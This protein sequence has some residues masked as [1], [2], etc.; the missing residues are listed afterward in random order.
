MQKARLTHDL[1]LDKSK[2]T[3]ISFSSIL[4]GAVLEEIAR[5]ISVSEYKENLW[6]KNG[7]V[8]GI[9]RYEKKLAL[10]LEYVYVVFKVGRKDADKTDE[11]FLTELFEG[12]REQAFDKNEDCGILVASSYKI[13]RKHLLIQLCA[14]LGDMK[15]PLSVRIAFLLD[16]EKIP[17]KESLP[18]M[19]FPNVSIEYCGY[20][21]EGV[22]AERYVEVITKLELIQNIGAYYEI[23]RLLEHESVDGRKVKEYIEER[24]GQLRIQKE[25]DRLD[26]IREYKD[27]SYMKKKWKTYLRG[28]NSKEPSW[29]AA[30]ERFLC[31]FTPIWEA[32]QNDLVFFGDWMP[33]LN[34]FL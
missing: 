5:R 19:M 29:E 23:Y 8:L 32:V 3:G 13:H 7:G 1:I 4:G 2:E 22:L 9:G 20:P 24:C 12:L 17:K 30:L 11:M 31:F 21:A 10:K 14:S 15:V 25:T 27:Y 26:M 28:I 18:C 16:D 6:L 33:E 34:R